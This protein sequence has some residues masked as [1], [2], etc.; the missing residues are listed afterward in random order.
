VREAQIRQVGEP[1][2]AVCTPFR[3]LD[4]VPAQRALRPG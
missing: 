3:L 4:N 2:K 1:L